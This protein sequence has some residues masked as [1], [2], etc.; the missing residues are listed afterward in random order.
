MA[1]LLGADLVGMS[2]VP[3][4]IL[5]RFH[6]LPCAA[7]S[8]VTNLGAGIGD[9]D[10]H[11]AETKAAAAQAGDALARLVAAYVARLPASAP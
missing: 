10:P 6:G 3:E 9:G 8:V 11:H 7:V 5:S 1:G 2:T 4:V